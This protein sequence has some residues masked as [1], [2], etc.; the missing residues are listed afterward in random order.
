MVTQKITT[1]S[2]ILRISHNYCF[3]NKICF[4]DR[5]VEKCKVMHLELMRLEKKR[6]RS[7][8]IEILSS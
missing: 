3:Y 1:E 5:D 6:V 2:I 4:R 8:F 7:D